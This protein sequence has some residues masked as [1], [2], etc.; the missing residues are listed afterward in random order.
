MRK[1]ILSLTAAAIALAPAAAAASPAGEVTLVNGK[2]GYCLTAEP[3]Q[4][5]VGAYTCDGSGPQK[6]VAGSSADGG[7][8][9]LN[10]QTGR[11]F[12]GATQAGKTVQLCDQAAG[13]TVTP[14]RNGDQLHYPANS[15]CLM[16]LGNHVHLADCRED[17]TRSWHTT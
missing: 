1:L 12:C 4:N 10:P 6:W 9:Y 8:T 16:A 11:Y 2:Q 5:T 3:K 17:P 13:W 7:R 14:A 15:K